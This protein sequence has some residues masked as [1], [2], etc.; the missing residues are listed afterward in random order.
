[1][2]VSLNDLF[3][4]RSARSAAPAAHPLY[5][6]HGRARAAVRPSKIGFETFEPRVLLSA[7]TGIDAAITTGLSAI[8][9]ELT[10]LLTADDPNVSTEM[11]DSY[12]PGILISQGSGADR[13]EIS[14]TFRQAMSIEV[15]IN[16]DGLAPNAGSVSPYVPQAND[17]DERFE[18]VRDTPNFFATT[19]QKTEAA[20]RAMDLNADGRVSLDE[21]FKV[22]VVGQIE[23]YLQD[24]PIGGGASA[25]NDEAAATLA[26]FLDGGVLVGLDVPDNV[27][28]LVTLDVDAVF[29]TYDEDSNTLSWSMQ[30]LVFGLKEVDTFDLGYQGDQLGILLDPDATTEAQRTQVLVHRTLTF[31]NF[32]FGFR[33]AGDAVEA[34]SSSDFFF[35]TPG[36]VT[37]EVA[38]DSSG[39]DIDAA[40]ATVNVGF[41]GTTVTSSSMTLDM[42]ALGTAIDPSSAIAFGFTAGQL[43]AVQGSGGLTAANS[44]DATRLGAADIEFIVRVGGASSAMIPVR[45]TVDTSPSNTA[46]ADLVNAVN[47]AIATNASLDAILQASNDGGKLRIALTD[48]DNDVTQLGFAAEQGG[49]IT[50]FTA[51]AASGLIGLA[52]P[53]T[54]ITF[55]IG[56]GTAVPRLVTVNVTNDPLGPDGLSGDAAKDADNNTVVTLASLKSNLQTALNTAFGGGAVTVGDNGAGRLTLNGNGQF[57]Q[58]THSLK[59]DT[60]EQI[61]LAELQGAAQSFELAADAGASYVAELNLT[62]KAGLELADSATAYAPTGTI[63]VDVTPFT[64]DIVGKKLDDGSNNFKASYTLTDGTANAD[65]DLNSGTSEMQPML[66]WNVIGPADILGTINQIGNWAERLAGT[67]L[68]QAFDLPFADV[69]LGDLLNFKDVV[70]DTL[71]LDDGDDGATKPGTT[72]IADAQRLLKWAV[73]NGQQQLI[74][75]FATAQQL[76]STLASVMVDLGLADNLADALAQLDASVLKYTE[77]GLDKQDLV[78]RLEIEENL[79]PQVGGADAPVSVPLDF[80][81]DSLAPL[82]NF[83]TS[84]TLKITALGEFGF[85]LGIKLGN[86]VA[87]LTDTSDLLDDLNSGQGIKV[88]DNLAVTSLGAIDPII[89]RLSGAAVFTVTVFTGPATSHSYTVTLAQAPT[90][91]NK[92]VANLRADLVAAIAGA[93]KV[94]AAS[95]ALSTLITAANEAANTDPTSARLVLRATSASV[96]GFQIDSA[97]AVARDELGF[98]PARAAT[99]SLVAPIGISTADPAELTFNVKVVRNGAPLQDVNVTLTDAATDGNVAIDSLISDLNAALA[100]ALGVN[101]LLASQSGGVLVISAVASDIIGFKVTPGAGPNASIGLSLTAY[102]AT[103]TNASVAAGD[104]PDGLVAGVTL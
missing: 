1:M 6:K 91:D 87:A 60:N 28:A 34:V 21:A 75:R 84:G 44:P 85:T 90:L 9:A 96:V 74:A 89:G 12:V 66:D 68:L 18:Y 99:V 40:S 56:R 52:A 77:G 4:L 55:L 11:F 69:T 63:S 37:L 94:N 65:N 83:E 71:L 78:V 19:G 51:G 26:G 23:S 92:T 45:L 31:A 95:P 54:P 53:A 22:I 7:D 42:A 73:V 46:I 33:G 61:T 43:G 47:A 97:N 104:Q 35:A 3:P 62:A 81:F 36:G 48:T 25:D 59:I 76:E 80:Q 20:L 50:S 79:L 15:D 100:A 103:L 2:S 58:I 17:L 98:Q 39:N 101:Q 102:Q 14:P 67:D 29:G 86:A 24:N 41:L 57:L 64:S 30:N 70:A 93:V 10:Q 82:A 5:R 16:Q 32:T 72:G 49:L 27:D 88:N 13:V 38:A 8:G